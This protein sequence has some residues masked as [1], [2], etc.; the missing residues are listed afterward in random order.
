MPASPPLPTWI[1]NGPCLNSCHD[2]N[3][4]QTVFVGCEGLVTPILLKPPTGVE[5]QK[6]L[7][8]NSCETISA[9]L[10]AVYLSNGCGDALNGPSHSYRVC[11][12]NIAINIY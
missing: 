9:R 12:P 2:L 1:S 6:S 8:K 7:S 4:D 5:K 10:P 11:N 3:L